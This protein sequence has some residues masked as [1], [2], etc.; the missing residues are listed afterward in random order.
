MSPEDGDVD[1]SNSQATNGR[2]IVNT[3]A[4]FTCRHGYDLSGSNSSICT[5][6]LDWTSQAPT[7][8]QGND[9]EL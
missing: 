7:C 3:N 5:I 1:Y 9:M 8:D 4:M 6:T 2:Y